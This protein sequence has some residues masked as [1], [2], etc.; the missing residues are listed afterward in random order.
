MHLLSTL[1]LLPGYRLFQRTYTLRFFL[2]VFVLFQL[3]WPYAS[4]SQSPS[5]TITSSNLLTCEQLSTTLT[6]ATSCTGTIKYTFKGP[7][8]FELVNTTGEARV[9]MSGSYSVTATDA[10]G[11]CTGNAAIDVG[12]N[13]HPDYLPL[14]NLYN[15]T[16]GDSWLNH[17]GWLSN[18]DPCSG[19][20]GVSCA[21][22]RVT[23]LNLGNLVNRT[24]GNNLEGPFPQ[25]VG[26]LTK[27]R[28]LVVSFN[29]KL[30]GP[31]PS[32]LGQLT[33]LRYV[34]LFSNNFGGAIPASL[35][36]LANVDLLYLGFNGLTGTI[37]TALGNLKSVQDMHLGSNNLTGPI[38]SSFRQLK[39]LQRLAL[40]GN[41]L[42]GSVPDYFN[43]FPALSEL[44]LTIN[45]FTGPI[46][47]SL[48]TMNSLMVLSLAVNQLSGCIPAS[49]KN[50]CG[51]RVEING[52]AGLPGGG[53]WASFCANGL[54][55]YNGNLT[56]I[57]AGYWHDQTVW[58][59]GALPHFGDQVILQHTSQ[60]SPASP[61]RP[62]TSVTLLV[63]S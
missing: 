48:G 3:S 11:Y 7:Y 45:Q 19:W 22:G 50:L 53:D 2:L 26:G 27:L 18:C 9:T 32:S 1:L 63:G 33:D 61:V 55:E 17:S 30:T 56:T 14:A 43:E 47:A 38:P 52:N 16:R 46:P 37:P 24:Q 34:D 12:T 44:Y 62:G 28:K 59:C 4:Y 31:I 42:S 29:S 23:E 10:A 39:T 54:G 57:K 6:A 13:L 5:V 21:D 35:G 49:L 41:R 8:D 15:S 58:S 20:F 60:S 25:T 36:K 51:R 40:S